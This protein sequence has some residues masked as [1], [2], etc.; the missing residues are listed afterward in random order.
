MDSLLRW[1]R[2]TKEPGEAQRAESSSQESLVQ[3]H[4]DLERAQ[5]R[6]T[7]SNKVARR[8]REHNVANHYDDWL[9]EQFLKYYSTSSSQR[10]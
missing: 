1:F 6:L 10:N 4:S 8:I 9:C 3:A 5:R 7:E 2:G